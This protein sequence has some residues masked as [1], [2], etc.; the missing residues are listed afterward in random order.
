MEQWVVQIIVALLTVSGSFVVAR[1]TAKHQM[2]KE[3][4]E[5]RYVVYKSVLEY[6][7]RLKRDLGYR[8][9]EEALKKLLDLE[10]DVKICGSCNLV[11]LIVALRKRLDK[12]LTALVDAQQYATDLLES[13]LSYRQD[14]TGCT[15]E[16]ALTE[17]V[18]KYNLEGQQYSPVL[19]DKEI[20]DCT[21]EIVRELRRS[22]GYK[23]IRLAVWFRKTWLYRKVRIWN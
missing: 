18:G 11:T 7:L 2:K 14:L 19:T 17:L 4:F 10:A 16:E 9:Q 8:S 23:E 22:L 5:R 15:K 1:F 20:D 13:E 12:S 3:L 21:Q 6:L